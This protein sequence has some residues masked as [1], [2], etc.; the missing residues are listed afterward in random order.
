MNSFQKLDFS[1]WRAKPRPLKFSITMFFIDL[2][3]C[4]MHWECLKDKSLLMDNV[5]EVHFGSLPLFWREQQWFQSHCTRGSSATPHKNTPLDVSL[6]LKACGSSALFHL[7]SRTHRSRA[8]GAL[9]GHTGDSTVKQQD[10]AWMK[11][12]ALQRPP[13]FTVYASKSRILHRLRLQNKTLHEPK[14]KH[15]HA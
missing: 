10:A 4:P 8:F 6:L 1:L 7:S 3:V 14:C 15:K 13:L 9:T 5:A 2:S 11:K 12:V